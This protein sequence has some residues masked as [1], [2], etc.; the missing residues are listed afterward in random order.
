MSR[1]N[2]PVV[3][4]ACVMTSVLLASGGLAAA[5][6][7]GRSPAADMGTIRGTVTDS[8]GAPLAGVS[9]GAGDYDQTVDCQMTPHGD[10]TAGDG[11]YRLEVPAGSYLVFANSHDH[12][13][14]YVP[15]AYEGVSS[16]ANIRQARRVEVG[17]GQA[18]TGV[19]MSLATGF[20][21]SGR[22]VDDSGQPVL[23]A[24]SDIRDPDRGIEF[25]C[26]LGFGSSDV[27]GTFRVNL[28]AG[29]Y[30]LHMGGK[31]VRYQ[32]EVRTNL[33]LGDVL[34]AEAVPPLPVFDPRVP[35]GY[36]VEPF[37]ASNGLPSPMDTAVTPSGEVYAC[38]AGLGVVRVGPDGSVTTI[39]KTCAFALDAAADG[40]L[41]GYCPSDGKLRRVQPDGMVEE[42]AEVHASC[43]DSPLV[44]TPGGDYLVAVNTTPGGDGA[45]FLYKVTAGGAVS[46]LLSGLPQTLA[47]AYDSAGTLVAGIGDRLVALDPQS[48]SMT[49][50]ATIPGP[51]SF[52]G[53]VGTTDGG[54]YVSTGGRQTQGG[55]YR[56]SPANQVQQVAYRTD[57]GL[58]GIALGT[59]GE[60]LAPQQRIS[61]LLRIWPDGRVESVV[62]P[63]GIST[64]HALAF[65]LTGDLLI[66]NVET[67]ILARAAP[68]GRVMPFVE[69][70]VTFTPPVAQLAVNAD[71]EIFFSEAAPGFASRVVRI[72]PTGQVSTQADDLAI[73]CG[74]AF[75]ADGTLHAADTG[76]GQIVALS[77]AGAVT[78]IVTGLQA[79]QNLAVSSD[80]ALWVTDSDGPAQDPMDIPEPL[81]VYRIPPGGNLDLVADF[82]HLRWLSGAAFAPS[83][84]L[85]VAVTGQHSGY[86]Y[87][88]SS[89]GQVIEFASGFLNP[90]GLAF[91]LDGSL[92]VSDDQDN[93]ITRISGFP[94]GG[95]AGSITAADDGLPIAEAVV[96]VVRGY[97][98]VGGRQVMADGS[99]QF[100]TAAAAGTYTVTASAPGYGRRSAQVTVET[101]VTTT[102]NLAL[103]AVKASIYLP[104]V[105]K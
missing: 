32:M 75:D 24:G 104:I 81:W 92:Y 103:P 10:Q 40:S 12:P 23:G 73:P 45:T 43:C 27:D 70:L 84:D 38:S 51:V 3:R 74:L 49:E 67:T 72:S 47:L 54:F 90:V 60:V 66:S 2:R 88:V 14:G 29:S 89:A 44:E 59:E 64:P 30:D 96:T 4:L 94:Q 55:L 97:P 28:P 56:V 100:D 76:E 78:P 65:S 86:L 26:S 1:W 62:A 42:M 25:G 16:W 79:P 82:H 102:V 61:A 22:L 39:A 17:A 13:G 53:I 48:G 85:Y 63:N 31:T 19:D 93:S 20:T 46:Q 5:P 80:G 11:S 58:M 41:V 99:G 33:H 9:I 34:Y 35:P 91:D 50:R 52:E 15:Q 21:L 83:G 77:T 6:L 105:R 37:I 57:S 95:I 18:V 7:S 87:T 36:E 71:G 8:Q 69:G 101:G 68:D 98:L